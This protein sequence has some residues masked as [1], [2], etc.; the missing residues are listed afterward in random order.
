MTPII[1][2][3]CG[4][5]GC[6]KTTLLNL[7]SQDGFKC[8]L[9]GIKDWGD[10][11]ELS[12]SEPEKYS[13]AFQLRIISEQT[14]QKE[15]ILK[16]NEK[17]VFIER[18]SD[19]GRHVFV[20]AKKQLSHLDDVMIAEFDRWVNIHKMGI[21]PHKTVYLRTTPEIAAERIQK[22]QQAGDSF[23]DKEYLKMLHELY[24]KRYSSDPNIL[25][26]EGLSPQESANKIKEWIS[27]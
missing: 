9:E 6:G 23:I 8:M 24:E 15:S 13:L 10:I 19:D 4:N 14:L 18:S 22:R 21:Q 27:K 5:I 16:M 26:L 3:I 17:N 1:I 11:L 25:I 2:S 20:N 12:Y 7:L